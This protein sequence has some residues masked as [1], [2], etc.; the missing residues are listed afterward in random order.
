M[1]FFFILSFLLTFNF[2]F[3]VKKDL[4]YSFISTIL[5]TSTFVWFSSELLSYFNLY[6]YFYISIFWIIYCFITLIYNVK[7]NIY[8]NLLFNKSV[9]IFLQNKKLVLSFFSFLLL[10][11]FQ[12]LVFP[13]NNWDSLTYHMGRIPHWIINQNLKPF[14]TPIYRQIYSP[15]FA[16]LFIAQISILT[17]SDFYANLIQL[18]FFMGCLSFM[19]LIGKQLNFNKKGLL[20][21]LFLALTTPSII[22]QTN[23]TQNDLIISF[24]I[25]SVLFYCIKSYLAPSNK[26]NFLFLGIS[27]G[28]A[29]YTKGTAYIFLLPILITYSIL[30]LKKVKLNRLLF[31]F[32]IIIFSIVAINSNFYYR[33]YKL[34]GDIFGKNDDRLF[35]EKMNGKV[36]ILNTI[37][38]TSNHFGLPIINQYTN[39]VIEKLHLVLDEPINDIKTNFNGI[40]FKLEKWQHHEDNAS[41]FFQI[42]IILLFFAFSIIYWKKTNKLYKLCFI[43]LVTEI[44]LFNLLLKWQPWH[45]R[46]TI[47]LFFISFLLIGFASNFINI[48]NKKIIN[49]FSILLICY[50]L[51]IIIFNPIKPYIS[52]KKYTSKINLFDSRFKKY[53]ANYPKLNADYKKAINFINSHPEDTSLELGGD[54]WDYLFYLNCFQDNYKNKVQ[55]HNIQNR[56]KKLKQEVK[57]NYIISYKEEIEGYRLSEKN[58]LFN[59]FVKH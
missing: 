20:I 50:S 37:K 46:L 15:P 45:T 30:L 4:F 29:F 56:T 21:V 3:S 35:N 47:P 17:R 12:G 6:N 52:N 19:Y 8:P 5:I 9:K 22:L 49:A 31:P 39:Q 24:F 48:F 13:S 2:F 14:P 11:S 10:L 42:L 27:I 58:N 36:F 32:G 28:L 51:S 25:L 43:V 59:L 1:I 23:S 40:S 53:C 26:Y 7:H 18:L 16:E 55:Y 54:M 38:N 57:T 41:N 33:N 44:V 34:S